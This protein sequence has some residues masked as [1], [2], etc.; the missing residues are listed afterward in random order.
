MTPKIKSTIKT[1]VPLAFALLVILTLTACGGETAALP[2]PDLETPNETPKESA[3]SAQE[4]L[5]TLTAESINIA[6]PRVISEATAE[7]D[8]EPTIS[9]KTIK[10]KPKKSAPKEPE[11]RIASANTS[12]IGLP[13]PPPLLDIVTTADWLGDGATSFATAPSPTRDR[14]EFLQTTGMDL[15]SGGF[16]TPTPTQRLTLKNGNG[17]LTLDGDLTDGVAFFTATPRG[18]PRHYAGIFSGTNLGAPLPVVQEANA[19]ASHAQWSGWFQTTTGV[20]KPFVMTVDYANRLFDAE[21]MV[22]GGGVRFVLE[23][24]F[25]NQGAIANGII[26]LADFTTGNAENATI[27]IVT[28][29]FGQEG[30]VGAFISERGVSGEASHFAGGFVATPE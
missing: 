2:N 23:G 22:D 14:N 6:P 4:T 25:D 5:E 10:P 16:A 12:T 1:P 15:D 21:V 3:K 30:A 17:S 24:G 27:G 11:F 13:P 26:I 18:T 8:T 19:D 7:S 29:L 28:G 9:I 20:S